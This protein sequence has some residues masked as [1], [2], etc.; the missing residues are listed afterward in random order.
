L[1]FDD[2]VLNIEI[3]LRFANV[4]ARVTCYPKEKAHRQLASEVCTLLVKLTSR[5]REVRQRTDKHWNEYG[6]YAS[7]IHAQL[8][9]EITNCQVFRDRHI[10][11]SDRE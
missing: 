10:R 9:V 4:L 2:A 6:L 3:S 5:Y 1:L 11:Y 8:M 7:G